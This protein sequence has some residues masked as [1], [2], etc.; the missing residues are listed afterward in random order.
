MKKSST[1]EQI[2]ELPLAELHPFKNHPFKAKDDDV[3]METADSIR[4]YGVLV[5]VIARPRSEGGYEIIAGHRRHRAS[6]LAKKKQC[7]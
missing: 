1:N 5:P 2:V 4:Q 7:R 3:M 6:E